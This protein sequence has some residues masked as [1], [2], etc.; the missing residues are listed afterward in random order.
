VRVTRVL[1]MVGGRSG[2][3]KVEDL[4]LERGAGRAGLE[5][6]PRAVVERARCT[7][8]GDWGVG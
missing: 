7:G 5:G 6:G 1:Y 8:Q 2:E 4:A 3:R